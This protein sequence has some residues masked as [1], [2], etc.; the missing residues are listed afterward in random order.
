MVDQ[1]EIPNSKAIFGAV[2]IQYFFY[3]LIY[4]FD[5]ARY[6]SLYG[7]NTSV[8]AYGGSNKG[9]NS[10]AKEPEEMKEGGEDE[11]V[12]PNQVHMEA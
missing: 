1:S 2:F 8:R 10:G 12:D 11:D 7:M 9:E 5:G 4:I 3:A 6:E